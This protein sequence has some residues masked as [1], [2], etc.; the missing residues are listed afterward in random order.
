MEQDKLSREEIVALYK[1]DVDRLAQYLNWL[2]QKQGQQVAQ[3]YRGQEVEK[4]SMT[5]PV[6]DATLLQLI[7][8]A[9]KT[10]LMNKNYPY[11]YSQHGIRQEAQD[12]LRAVRGADL[13]DFSVLCGILSRYV[14]RGMTKA[15]LWQEGAQS[16]VFYAVIGKMKE[17]LDLYGKE[18]GAQKRR[19]E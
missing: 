5:F 6:Y 4:N 12:E 18:S 2:K 17:L 15:H 3:H 1:P 9:Q 10:K 13:K 14:L 8:T 16:G 11:V 19:G 7:R